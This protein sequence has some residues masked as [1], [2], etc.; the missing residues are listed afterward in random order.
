MWRVVVGGRLLYRNR[1]I[2]FDFFFLD[3][4]GLVLIEHVLLL[5]RLLLLELLSVDV[6]AI[7]Y[8]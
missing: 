5:R 1:N 7:Q 2:F 8:F 4:L 3:V 6:Q